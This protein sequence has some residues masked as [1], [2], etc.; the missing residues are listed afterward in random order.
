MDSKLF[1]HQLREVSDILGQGLLGDSYYAGDLKSIFFNDNLPPNKGITFFF[2]LIL[3][4][5]FIYLFFVIN[6]FVGMQ[7]TKRSLG[8]RVLPVYVISLGKADSNL[9]L[10]K[11]YQVAA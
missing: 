8:T 6:N 7:G 11:Y 9:L 5:L 3:L 2:I 4:S 1:A 10:D